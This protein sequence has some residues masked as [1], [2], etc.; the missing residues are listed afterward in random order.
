MIWLIYKDQTVENKLQVLD[1]I[2][3]RY[4]WYLNAIFSIVHYGFIFLS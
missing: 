1:S 2:V 4:A 3:F